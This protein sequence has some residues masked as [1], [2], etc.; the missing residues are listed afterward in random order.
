MPE[1]SAWTGRMAAAKMARVALMRGKMM[2]GF[3][4]AKKYVAGNEQI[5]S[6]S[7]F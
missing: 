6:N 1:G 7:P 5:S 2:V 3:L 4:E